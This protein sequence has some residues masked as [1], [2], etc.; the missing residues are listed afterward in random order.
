LE[1]S[2][3]QL[4]VIKLDLGS[5]TLAF[6]K[7]GFFR[8]DIWAPDKP[9]IVANLED[10]FPFASGS[11]DEIWTHHVLEHI[12]PH[13]LPFFASEA[14]RILKAGGLW[15]GGL[16][17]FDTICLQYIQGKISFSE[18]LS[19]IYGG[20]N[21]PWQEHKTHFNFSTLQDLF[22]KAGFKVS[23]EDSPGVI[24]GDYKTAWWFRWRAWK[25]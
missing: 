6:S 25:V 10:P 8:V 4:T 3:V 21:Q 20:S 1:E 17:N 9:D 7:P 14:F 12:H 16:D 15:A 23:F 22:V 11:V 2:K 24:D 13:K 18:T 5:S 19:K